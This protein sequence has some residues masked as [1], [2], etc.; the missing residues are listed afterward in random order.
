MNN[1]EHNQNVQQTIL[2]IGREIYMAIQRKDAESLE[3]FLADDFVHRSADGTETGR[4]EFLRG[5]REMPF[6]INSIS[7]QHERV[8]FY[9]N[10]AVMTGVQNAEWRQSETEHGLNSVAFADVFELRDTKW[11]LVLAFGAELQS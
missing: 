7:G 9:G 10:V 5:I 3:R 8:S 6:M 2:D 1:P 4:Q 11:L